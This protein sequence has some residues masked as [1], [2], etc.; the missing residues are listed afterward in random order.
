MATITLGRTAVFLE[1]RHEAIQVE[2]TNL[3]NLVNDADLALARSVDPSV[4]VSIK[5]GGGTEGPIGRIEPDGSGGAVLLPPAADAVAGTPEG[6]ITFAD[7]ERTLPFANG[8]SLLTVRRAQLIEALDHGISAALLGDIPGAFPQVSGLTF[9]FDL[10]RPAGARIVSAALVDEAGTIVDVLVRDGA[11]VGD[12]EAPVR[13]VTIVFLADGGDDYPYPSF[14][15]DDPVFADRVDLLGEDRDGDGA[16]DAGEDTNRNGRLDAAPP[17]PPGATDLAPAGSERDAL[18]DHLAARYL[19]A[20]YDRAETPAALDTRIQNLAARADGVLDAPHRL[21]G[22]A[23]GDD[24][25]GGRAN[26]TLAGED[27]DDTLG[28]SDG[29]DLLIGAGGADGITAGAGADTVIGGDASDLIDG[30]VGDDPFLAGNSGIDLVW[31]G[32]GGD[33]LWGGQDGDILDGG[34]GADTLSGDRGA[35]TLAGGLGDDRFVFAPG[36]GRDVVRDFDAAHDRIVLAPGMAVDLRAGADG[37]AVLA[38]GGDQEIVLAG[39]TAAAFAPLLADA[40][41]FGA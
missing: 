9:S 14:V 25:R 35:D 38:L 3:G 26:D 22:A 40:I 6:A 20:P 34:D 4:R 24:L 12:A 21:V 36:H 19:E 29:D 16:L 11:L 8:L 5:N 41:L 30:G 7:V 39:W 32:A 23:A 10:T 1:G 15:A 13:I 27:G 17:I 31:G 2:E 33:R 18:A 37:N 28:G